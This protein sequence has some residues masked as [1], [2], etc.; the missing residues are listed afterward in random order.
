[1]NQS[2]EQPRTG[3]F[4]VLFIY[5]D[6]EPHLIGPFETVEERDVEARETRFQ[7]GSEDGGVYWLTRNEDDELECGPYPG[8]FF[9][10]E[11]EES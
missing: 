9:E 3:Q 7:N 2:M 6:V 1:M 4:Y 11:T 8:T 5:G 10:E